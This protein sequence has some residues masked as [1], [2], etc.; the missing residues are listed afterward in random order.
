M[1][2]LRT[3]II[4]AN[5]DQRLMNSKLETKTCESSGT[6]RFPEYTCFRIT[7]IRENPFFSHYCTYDLQNL[8]YVR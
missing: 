7:L 8:K 4:F 3:E 1:T 2:S 6:F 5:I